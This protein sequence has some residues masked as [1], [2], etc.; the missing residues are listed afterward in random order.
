MGGAQQWMTGLG[1]LVVAGDLFHR[2]WLK[3]EVEIGRVY[4]ILVE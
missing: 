3:N 1:G 4:S 2:G